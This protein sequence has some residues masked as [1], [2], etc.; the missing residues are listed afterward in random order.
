MRR[1]VILIA[2]FVLA[3]LC[4]AGFGWLADQVAGGHTAQFD[5]RV[6]EVIHTWAT[7]A[8]TRSMKIMSFIG[9]PYI[10][11]PLLVVAL[12]LRERLGINGSLLVIA[13]AGEVLI[14]QALK[15]GFRRARPEPFFGYPLPGSYSFPSGHALASLVFF[16]TFTAVLSPRLR[17][18]WKHTLLWTGAALLIAAIGFSRIY[19]GVHYPTDVIGGYAAGL[20]W[21]F[22][23][24][25]GNRARR[26]RI[27]RV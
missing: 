21:V 13:M 23:I 4:A 1:D 8:L 10:I 5:N 19:L 26:Q 11:W 22:T 18:W 16:G 14:E 17:S 25:A 9:E 2:G 20:A 12:L 7:P 27:K 3:L 24:A 6:R 15:F